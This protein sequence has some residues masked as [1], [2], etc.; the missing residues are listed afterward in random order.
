MASSAQVLGGTPNVQTARRP[1][2]NAL[3]CQTAR[4]SLRCGAGTV[5]S[6]RHRSI[7]VITAAKDSSRQG[8]EE[9]TAHS[10]GANSSGGFSGLVNNLLFGAATSL[11]RGDATCAK[12]RG[13][14]AVSCPSCKGAG[15]KNQKVRMNQIRHAF[16]RVKNMV[17]IDSAS[18]YDTQ[19]QMSNR[20]RKCHGQ[21]R[22]LCSFCNGIGAR[23]PSKLASRPSEKTLS[24]SDLGKP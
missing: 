21:G 12:C 16:N 3:Q 2:S 15:V 17:G 13:C 23:G 20:C 1:F 22:V 6:H 5:S 24:R 11:E 7:A 8:L 14:G 9:K 18:M 4:H 10:E 19:W